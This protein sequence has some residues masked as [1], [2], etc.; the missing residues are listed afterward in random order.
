LE[1][2]PASATAGNKAYS[3]Y[4]LD[5]ATGLSKSRTAIDPASVA[6]LLR[7]LLRDPVSGGT[8]GNLRTG[9]SE[10]GIRGGRL[11]GFASRS[12]SS[13]SGRTDGPIWANANGA[14]LPPSQPLSRSWSKSSAAIPMLGWPRSAADCWY[15]LPKEAGQPTLER[16]CS[17]PRRS[18]FAV[19]CRH[20]LAELI[21]HPRKLTGPAI[22]HV[23]PDVQTSR[24]IGRI[25]KKSANGHHSPV[26]PV[27]ASYSSTFESGRAVQTGSLT[28]HVQL[29]TSISTVRS[30][31]QDP[32]QLLQDVRTNLCP[33]LRWT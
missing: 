18:L 4:P 1:R 17:Y 19:E 27:H 15:A 7:H 30:A 20:A 16:P 29:R 22:S 11:L 21:C 32:P 5:R 3:P 25:K 23:A 26:C 24:E 6:I 13:G 8:A 14:A 33:P 2:L 28:K 31:E 9:G 10:L 12:T